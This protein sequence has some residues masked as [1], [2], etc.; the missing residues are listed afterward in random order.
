M[1]YEPSDAI[2]SFDKNDIQIIILKNTSS[3]D[4]IYK[5]ATTIY[6][7]CVVKPCT[8]VIPPNGEQKIIIELHKKENIT[9][10]IK[11]LIFYTDNNSNIL[12]QNIWKE[13]PKEQI[14]TIKFKNEKKKDDTHIIL[15]ELNN[16][17]NNLN[18]ELS[19]DLKILKKINKTIKKNQKII[20]QTNEIDIQCDIKQINYMTYVIYLIIFFIGLCAGVKLVM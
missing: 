19:T 15:N 2:L 20:K 1:Q 5:V 6:K 11:F 13:T 3:K 7:N 9:K 4:I 16:R 10:N 18:E 12:P 14:D 17:E 8:A